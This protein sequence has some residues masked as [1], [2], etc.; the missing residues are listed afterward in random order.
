MNWDVG[1]IID[2]SRK[3]YRD[4]WAITF[5]DKS[6]QAVILPKEKLEVLASDFYERHSGGCEVGHAYDEHGELCWL[7]VI[8]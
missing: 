8:C 3:D 6:E 5:A 7:G 1:T 4:A 2:I